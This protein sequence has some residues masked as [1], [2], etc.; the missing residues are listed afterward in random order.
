MGLDM[1][2]QHSQHALCLCLGVCS[3]ICVFI[4]N[5]NKVKKDSNKNDKAKEK[6]KGSDDLMH[7][8]ASL[9]K[10]LCC[11]RARYNVMLA[12]TASS[13]HI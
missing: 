6:W 5:T 1:H 2:K 13:N 11:R 10:C 9:C 3:S 8:S 12:V 4:E 7:S